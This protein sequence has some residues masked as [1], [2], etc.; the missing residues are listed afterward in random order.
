MRGTTIYRSSRVLAVWA[1]LAVMGGVAHAQDTLRTGPQDSVHV[2]VRGETLWGLADRYLGDPLLWPEI[3]RLNPMVVEDP[4]WIFP[5]EELLLVPGRE[6]TRVVR[7]PGDTLEVPEAAADTVDP[8]EWADRPPDVADPDFDVPPAPVAPP[9][10]PAT[11]QTPSVFAR[12]ARARPQ[13]AV[14]RLGEEA[15]RYRAVREGEFYAAG[16]LTEGERLPWADVLGPTRRQRRSFETRSS[17]LVY[18]EIRIRAPAGATYAPGDSLLLARL[19]QA[20]S[21]FG[22]VVIPAGIARVTYVDGR[23]VLADLVQQYDRVM[24][25][26][27]AMPLEPF[28]DPGSVVPV[29]VD[30]GMPG[31]VLEIRDGNVVPGQQDIVFIDRGRQDGVA[32]GDLFVAVRAGGMPNAPMDTLAYLQIVHVRERSASGMLTYINDTGIAPGVRVRLF[33]KM[34]S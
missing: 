3:Y 31:V 5:G 13:G 1:A 11:E 34:P 32:L 28:R 12:S 27:V 2:V 18:A 14:L 30:D 17:A 21:R 23:D 9:P 26:Q 16:F 33:R 10:P 19:A 6:T 4:H 24:D 7:L 22:R 29:P 8:F 15:L 20:V 25:G